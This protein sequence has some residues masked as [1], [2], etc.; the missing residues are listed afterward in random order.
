MR[1]GRDGKE[2]EGLTYE[3]DGI[4]I[5]TCVEGGSK[6]EEKYADDKRDRK[7]F[8]I[9]IKGR[10][11]QGKERISREGKEEKGKWEGL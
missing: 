4:E 8:Q 7:Y 9:E 5:K 3:N 10:G 11:R 2:E 6:G 1:D